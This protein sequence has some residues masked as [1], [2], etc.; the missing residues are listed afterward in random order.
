MPVAA[1]KSEA[2][3]MNH[4]VEQLLFLARG[5]SGR[6]QLNFE[7][8]QLDELM[9]EIYED[10]LLID[11]IHD[12]RIDI[13]PGVSCT[14]DHDALKQCAR[15][16]ADNAMK[17]TPEKGTIHLRAYNSPDG[18]PRIEVQDSGMGISVGDAP[19]IFDRF[20]RSDPARNRQ[21]GGTGLGLSIARW[22]AERHGGHI[23]LISRPGIGTR[24]TVCLPK[25]KQS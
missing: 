6:N 10:C 24:M 12:F 2:D 18:N 9:K 5:D 16:L 1:I 8:V 7:P 3:Y 15:V 17:Y 21:S 19:H 20:Y 25:M 11:K 22:I 23:E 4:L 13:Q 14:G